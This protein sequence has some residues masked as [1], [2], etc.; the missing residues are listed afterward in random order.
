MGRQMAPDGAETNQM[1]PLRLFMGETLSISSPR[2]QHQKLHQ[3]LIK[4]YLQKLA[5]KSPTPEY[6]E[7]G[8]KYEHTTG[9]VYRTWDN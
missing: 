6:G 1:F 7:R 9:T 2:H 5:V 4:I 8:K 3:V